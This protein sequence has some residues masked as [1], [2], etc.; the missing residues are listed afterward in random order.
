MAPE[1]PNA[2]PAPPAQNTLIYLWAVL[3]VSA[4]LTQALVRLSAI[5]WEALSSGDMTPFQYGVCAVWS[6]MNAYMEGYRGFQKKFVPRVLARAH[7]LAENPDT[8]TTLLAPLYAMA[9]FRA[10]LRAKI[11]AWGV[12]CLVIVAI[13]L[14]R[15]LAQ[16]WRGI[17]DAGVVVG[18]GWGL[19][20]L[21]IGVAA[22]L[23]GRVPSGDPELPDGPG[24]PALS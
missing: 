3:G 20:A 19:F 23:S 6:L 10:T 9:Y 12:T 24:E 16:P 7:H 18:L 11:A 21:L 15:A 17:I 1:A 22:R 2:S 4:L 8:L 14:V 13:T 5:T